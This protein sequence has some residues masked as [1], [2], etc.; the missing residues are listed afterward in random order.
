MPQTKVFSKLYTLA[1]LLGRLLR[2]PRYWEG[3]EFPLGLVAIEWAERLPCHPSSYLYIRLTYLNTS[4]R[5]A[6]LKPMGGFNL[7]AIALP[8]Q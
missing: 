2:K 4:G 6:E 3:V 5:Q 1:L 7:G 8:K